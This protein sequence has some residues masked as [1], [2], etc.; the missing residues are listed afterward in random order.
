M[1][2]DRTE[3][4]GR[5]V[6]FGPPQVKQ[7]PRTIAEIC[8]TLDTEKQIEMLQNVDRIA[9]TPAFAVSIFFDPRPEPIGGFQ[10]TV[11]GPD[12]PV[13]VLRH[14]LAV[15]LKQLDIEETQAVPPSNEEPNAEVEPIRPQ[16]DGEDLS[17]VRT[18]EVVPS[19]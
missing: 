13:S 10:F 12:T 7:G 2:R 11:N 18:P 15:A 3:R 6:V 14:M 16:A 4:K 17:P 19:T 1:A 5:K 9:R 8:G